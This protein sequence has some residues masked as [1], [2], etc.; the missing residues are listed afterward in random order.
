MKKPTFFTRLLALLILFT[1]L[2]VKAQEKL[3]LLSPESDVKVEGT[4]NLHDWTAEVKEFEGSLQVTPD[5]L[6]QLPDHLQRTAKGKKSKMPQTGTFASEVEMKFAVESLAGGRGPVMDKKIYQAF[7]SSENPHIVF[8]TNSPVNYRLHTE[9]ARQFV[10]TASGELIMAGKAKPATIELQGTLNNQQKF[11]F[12]GSKPLLMSHWG[13]EK[14][15]AMF[16]K[17]VTGDE[18]TIQFNLQFEEQTAGK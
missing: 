9:D 18:V 1:G 3:Y 5:F 2:Q 16:G 11:S 14:P 8:K 6:K 15:S 13:M 7:K 17:I 10:A 12:T 4:S